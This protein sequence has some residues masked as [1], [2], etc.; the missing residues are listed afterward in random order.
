MDQYSGYPVLLYYKK[1]WKILKYGAENEQ[2]TDTASIVSYAYVKLYS[3][4]VVI[5]LKYVLHQKSTSATVTKHEKTLN[6][7]LHR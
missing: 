6:L 2:N 3:F 7:L 5:Y 1:T 4:S